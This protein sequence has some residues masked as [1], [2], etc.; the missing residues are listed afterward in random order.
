MDPDAAPVA[1]ASMPTDC[2]PSTRSTPST[3]RRSGCA[4]A[5]M[6][7]ASCRS[8]RDVSGR[9]WRPPCSG[10][11][12][13]VMIPAYSAR[14][15]AQQSL[16]IWSRTVLRRHGECRRTA[17]G[18]DDLEGLPGDL[19]LLVGGHDEHRRAGG[20]RRDAART[21]ALRVALGVELDAESLESRERSFAHD[22]GVLA[23]ARGEDD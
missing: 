19:E 1:S 12:V 21:A 15:I 7:P 2:G 6:G 23:D 9:V 8:M 16:R 11:E 18:L 3:S 4:S 22:R 13:S 5:R 14:V 20:I 10:P 17:S